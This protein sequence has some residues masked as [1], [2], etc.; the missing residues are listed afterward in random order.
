MVNDGSP[1]KVTLPDGEQTVCA[2]IV[3]SIK[4]S[5]NCCCVDTI[6]STI[7]VSPCSIAQFNVSIDN[8]GNGNYYL[9]VNNVNG[10]INMNKNDWQVWDASG[11]FITNYSGTLFNFSPPQSGEYHICVKGDYQIILPKGDAIPCPL[12]ICFDTFLVGK[13]KPASFRAYPNPND[14][15]FILEITSFDDI[16]SAKLDIVDITGR[17][18]MVKEIE[19]LN[20]GTNRI[21]VNATGISNGMYQLKLSVNNSLLIGKMV[22]D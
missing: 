13:E 15:N 20:K 22:K 8:H 6:C 16:A 11:N 21:Y 4:D 17:V 1:L 10:T 3:W 5:A 2:Y 19:K 9:Y 18:V 7:D 12:T 14:G